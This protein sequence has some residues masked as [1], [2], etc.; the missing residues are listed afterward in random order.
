[1]RRAL[2]VDRDGV[3]DELVFYPSH[4][5]WEGPRTVADLRMIDGAAAALRRAQDVG[6]LLFIVTN[7]PSFAK[8]KTTLEALIEVHERV[9]SELARDGVTITESYRCYH[10]ASDACQ[11]RKPSPFFLREAA[12]HFSVDLQESWM[13]GDQDSDMGSGRAAGCRVALIENPH[14]VHKR[15]AI[16]P[17]A[18]YTSLAD[19]IA[20]IVG[21]D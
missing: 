20:A 14:S 4:E 12:R 6:W 11:C 10:Q 2:F 19:A 5:E 16:E 13:I 18:R 1:M 3:L 7:Q 15:G 17:D 9:L 21:A 8:G